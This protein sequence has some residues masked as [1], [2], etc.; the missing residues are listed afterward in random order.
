[1]TRP[2]GAWAVRVGLAL[3]ALA[4]TTAADA[5]PPSPAA[6][7]AALRQ[8]ADRHEASP[9]LRTQRWDAGTVA[10]LGAWVA[11]EGRAS[12]DGAGPTAE[13]LALLRDELTRPISVSVSGAVSLGS[14]QGGYL[15]YYLRVLDEARKVALDLGDRLGAGVTRGSLLSLVTG[16]SSGSINAFIAAIASC[17]KPVLEPRKSLFFQTWFPVSAEELDP[18]SAKR[19][20]E[21]NHLNKTVRTYPAGLLS[22]TPIDDAVDRVEKRWNEGEWSADPCE[23]DVGLSATRMRSRD[24]DPLDEAE[25]R[26]PRQ[27]EKIMFRVRGPGGRKPDLAPLVLQAADPQKPYYDERLPLLRKL[28]RQ[29]GGKDGPTLADVTSL[30]RASSAFSAAFPPHALTLWA[31]DEERADTS[32]YTDGGVFDNR[33]VGMAVE[34]QRWRLGVDGEHASKTRYMVADPDVEGFKREGTVPVWPLAAPAAPAPVWPSFLATWFPFIGDFVSTAFEVQIMDAL[35]REPTMY[36]GLEVLPRHAPV[37]GAY[38]MEF[39]AFAEDD[40]RVFDFYMGMVDAWEQLARTSLG[41]QV[42]AAAG[43]TPKVDHAPEFDCLLA[44]RVA[45]LAGQG[46][47]PA[48]VCAGVGLDGP[49]KPDPGL[50]PNIE[51]LARASAQTLAWDK[52][53]PPSARAQEQAKFLATLGAGPTPYVYRQLKYHGGAASAATVDLALRED[54]QEIIE[55]TTVEQPFG[56]E[57]LVVGSVGKAV[58]NYYV[59]RPPTGYLAAGLV[60]DRGFEILGALRPW[61]P[62]TPHWFDL[63]PDA[64]V[65]VIGIHQAEYDAGRT[66]AFTTMGALHLTGELQLQNICPSLTAFQS[67]VQFHFGVGWAAE[68]LRTWS[69]ALL[70]RHGPEVVLG[71]AAFQRLYLDVVYD[72]FLDDCAG[73]NRCSHA[74]P[75]I[76]PGVPPIVD[77]GWGL[78]F[79]LGYRFFLD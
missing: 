38:L 20:Y 31:L 61:D 56:V 60:S 71:A 46:E 70:W 75:S 58:A 15:Y 73:N 17:Q 45:T 44:W 69:R 74:N 5:A 35:E 6:Q 8:V 32:E 1:M 39:L 33:P 37:A 63:R 52:A 22:L 48:G 72:Q 27:T 51:A 29:L 2:K 77:A 66:V 53:S 36:A 64:A 13:D 79:S 11:A 14:Y 3:G 43:K 23:L 40:F 24:V 59:Y 12:K 18:V 7:G 25:L 28:F 50:R 4:A 10:R 30:L 78:R 42:L 47:P 67:T 54:L 57:S 34:M 68:S 41:F 16:A 49:E 65:R 55:H 9:I 26:L 62:R 19:F 76:S 21:R